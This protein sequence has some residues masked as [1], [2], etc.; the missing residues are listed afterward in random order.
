MPD[1]VLRSIIR[2]V[3]P[4]GVTGFK[5]AFR[6]CSYGY[7]GVAYCTRGSRAAEAAPGTVHRAKPTPYVLINVYR[8]AQE[9]KWRCPYKWMGTD[10]GLDVRAYSNTEAVVFLVAYELRHLW[11]ARIKRGSRVWG[12]RGRYS[13]RDADA[14]GLRMLRKWRR[15][16]NGTTQSSEA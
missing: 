14:H 11:Q 6:N 13:E 9:V 15:E 1:A 10:D 8:R 4:P 2:F 12:A 5:I 3:R 7:R 16:S